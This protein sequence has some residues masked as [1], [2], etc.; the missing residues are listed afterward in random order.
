MQLALAQGY[1][2][3]VDHQCIESRHSSECCPHFLSRLEGMYIYIGMVMQC[4]TY[5]SHCSSSCRTFQRKC[6]QLLHTG[7]DKSLTEWYLWLN[8]PACM[9]SLHTYLQHAIDTHWVK[10]V[11][12]W[13][14]LQ[15][16]H[17]CVHLI[18]KAFWCCSLGHTNLSNNDEEDH[19]R[20][21]CTSNAHHCFFTTVSYRLMQLHELWK[22]WGMLSMYIIRSAD[23]EYQCNK[24]CTACMYILY[25]AAHTKQCFRLY[26]LD[27][28][29][30]LA[31][32]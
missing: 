27:L 15:H 11:I 30:Q 3:R 19:N 14:V 25:T 8:D 18:N 32:S 7:W 17:E 28:S 9:L 29:I 16:T 24:P 22:T 5:Q 4:F 10:D 23:D 26:I 21:S 6:S 20:E 12:W 2:P 1:H 13:T 31:Q